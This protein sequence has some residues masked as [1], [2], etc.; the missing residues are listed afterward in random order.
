MSRVNGHFACSPVVNNSRTER[1]RR[2]VII[3]LPSTRVRS[4]CSR[5]TVAA[6]YNAI[7][8]SFLSARASTDVTARPPTRRRRPYS[9]SYLLLTSRLSPDAACGGPARKR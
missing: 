1:V 7:T 8:S 5:P 3:R 6:H 4:L 2:S 9:A